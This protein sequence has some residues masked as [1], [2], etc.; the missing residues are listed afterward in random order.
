VQHIEIEIMRNLPA[1]PVNFSFKEKDVPL[2]LLPTGS[3]IQLPG[4]SPVDGAPHK[5]R[6]QVKVNCWKMLIPIR[7]TPEV[8]RAYSSHCIDMGYVA[9]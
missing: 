9:L 8:T 5:S 4:F 2:F 6:L 1:K 7:L 3:M